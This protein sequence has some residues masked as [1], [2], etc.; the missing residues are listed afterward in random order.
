MALASNSMDDI[1]DKEVE[2]AEGRGESLGETAA[3][4]S[5]SVTVVDVAVRLRAG[6][7]LAAPEATADAMMNGRFFSLGELCAFAVRQLGSPQV[8]IDD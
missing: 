2:E 8:P 7:R 5:E 3:E 1:D 4:D 6:P